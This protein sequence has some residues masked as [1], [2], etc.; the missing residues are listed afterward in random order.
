MGKAEERPRV[1]P[2]TPKDPI[3]NEV[4]LLRDFILAE[5][6]TVRMH[7]TFLTNLDIVHYNY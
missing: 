2:S 5:K 1:D 3:T 7:E 4:E 6:A